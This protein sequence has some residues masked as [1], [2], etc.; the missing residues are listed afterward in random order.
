MVAPS[1]EQFYQDLNEDTFCGYQWC[2]QLYGYS[3]SN[4]GFLERV[5]ARLDELGRDKVKVIFALYMKWE[6][7]YQGEQEKDAAHWLV[8]QTD[9]NYERQVR[10]CKKKENSQNMKSDYWKKQ[11]ARIDELKKGLMNH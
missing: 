10:E 11:S 9:K 3:I 8:E 1:K 5:F 6:I 2:K 7:K 4:E